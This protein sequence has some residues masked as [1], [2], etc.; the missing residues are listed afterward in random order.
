MYSD[1]DAVD[2]V[3]EPVPLAW[4]GAIGIATASVTGDVQERE[5]SEGKAE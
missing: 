2:A 3:A 4:G 1:A 5:T